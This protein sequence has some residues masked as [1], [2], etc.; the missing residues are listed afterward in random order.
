MVPD[1]DLWI[2]AYGS[3]VWRPDFAFVERCKA[4]LSGYHRGLCISSEHYRGTP[5]RP[6]L[7]LGLDRGGSCQGVAFRIA[8]ADGPDTLDAVRRR[9]LITGVYKEITPRVRFVDG[10][11]ARAVTYVADRAHVQYAG[12]LDRTLVLD[13]VRNCVGQAGPNTDY[14]RNTHE[15]LLAFGI[16][17]PTL[18]WIVEALDRDDGRVT[19]G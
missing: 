6:G 11:A 9:E 8:A 15:H 3:L 18:A 2:F 13:R 10:R 1:D 7:V 5:A 19:L 17:D 14:V 16:S 12:T 4:R